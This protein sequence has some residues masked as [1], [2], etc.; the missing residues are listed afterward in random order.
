[1][2][3]PI[4]IAVAAAAAGKATEKT[5]DITTTAVSTLVNLVRTKIAGKPEAEEALAQAKQESAT[6]ADLQVLADQIAQLRDRDEEFARE[7]NELV[8]PGTTVNTFNHH[9]NVY[10]E[11]VIT[12]TE[13]KG[14]I[15][16]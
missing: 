2:S 4:L 10:A 11:K 12:A 9:G 5:I 6:D 14:D 16:M 15:H 1:M 7:F 13:I 8:P 3:D